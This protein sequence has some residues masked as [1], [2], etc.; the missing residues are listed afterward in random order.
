M[1]P[2]IHFYILKLYTGIE[3]NQIVMAGYFTLAVIPGM[4]AH[5]YGLALLQGLQMFRSF[6]LLRLMPV[7]AYAVTGEQETV[8]SLTGLVSSPDGKKVIKVTG[9]GN[10]A[11]KL[12]KKLAQE[13]L[14]QGAARILHTNS[15]E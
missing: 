13:A 9:E 15:K 3:H 14:A 11:I 2:I 7:A 8:I 5:R 12:G 1:L 4:L 6:N 10:N